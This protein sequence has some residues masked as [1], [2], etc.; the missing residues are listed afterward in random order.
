LLHSH[1]EELGAGHEVCGGLL[2]HWQREA[3]QP[4]PAWQLWLSTICIVHD[5]PPLTA[6]TAPCAQAPAAG[7][8]VH[9]QV[10][11]RPWLLPMPP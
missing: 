7:E 3:R 8:D 10:R 5:S 4:T 2:C 11:C 1:L 6:R 9:M